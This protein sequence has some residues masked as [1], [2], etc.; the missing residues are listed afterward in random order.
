LVGRVWHVKLFGVF[1]PRFC[2]QQVRHATVCFNVP[3][4]ASGPRVRGTL[5][6]SA[7]TPVFPT[8][9][10]THTH[11]RMGIRCSLKE[12]RSFDSLSQIH[13][14]A[15]THVHIHAH[16]RAHTHVHTHTHTRISHKHTHTHTHT[17]HNMCPK[18]GTSLRRTSQF[19]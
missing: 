9:T 14:H 7:V 3:L 16:A 13:T 1:E 12:W 2:L 19:F 11:A 10:H 5:S 18:I 15:R 8:H 6:R 4:Y 17:Q